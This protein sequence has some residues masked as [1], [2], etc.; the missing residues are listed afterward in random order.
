MGLVHCCSVICSYLFLCDDLSKLTYVLIMF[1][2]C[3][4]SVTTGLILTL[5]VWKLTE[6]SSP[7][8]VRCTQQR[9]RSVTLQKLS[10][11][12][13][14]GAR[15]T[16]SSNPVYVRTPGRPLPPVPAHESTLVTLDEEDIYGSSSETHTYAELETSV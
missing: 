15:W 6:I 2:C 7:D 10:R 12:P 11:F 3:T 4:L 13:F 1:G 5:T 14:G 9:S 16:I 8:L